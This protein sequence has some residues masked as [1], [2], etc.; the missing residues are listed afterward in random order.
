LSNASTGFEWQ[1]LV[2]TGTIR[3]RAKRDR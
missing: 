3:W 1:R 2:R